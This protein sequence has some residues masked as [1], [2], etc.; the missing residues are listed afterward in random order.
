MSEQTQATGASVVHQ[1]NLP[2]P[3]ASAEPRLGL[4][5]R[6]PAGDPFC[7]ILGEKWEKTHW[8]HSEAERE[9]AMREI[10]R[11]HPYYRLG[12]RPTLVLEKVNRP[13]AGD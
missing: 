8:F 12:D 2:S 1:H 6:L 11:Q 13:A 9:K 7:D 5:M 3:K 10:R 4:R